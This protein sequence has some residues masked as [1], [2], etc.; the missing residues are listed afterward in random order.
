MFALACFQSFGRTQDGQHRTFIEQGW[1]SWWHD[2][3]ESRPPGDVHSWLDRLKRWSAAEQFDQDYLPWRRT[4]VDLYTIA[5]WLDEYIELFRKLPRIIEDQGTISL[6]E[7]L[8]PSYSPVVM[9]LGLDAAPLLR[10]IGIGSNWM[11]REFLR[12]KVYDSLYEALLAPYSW[13]PSRRVRDL[14]NELGADVGEVADKEASRRMHQ[15]VTRH[16]GRNHARFS[17]D[18]DLPLQL[19][20]RDANNVVLAECFRAAD[21]DPPTFLKEE[22]NAGDALQ[23]EVANG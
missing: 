22:Q 19:I 5:R 18:F 8:R 7:L 13:A 12:F 16:L 21:R 10:S 17:G 4:F 14:L 15:F 20:T 11:I 2:M 23:A 1:E 3:A 9:P 6:N